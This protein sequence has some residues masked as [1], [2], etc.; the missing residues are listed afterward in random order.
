[1]IDLVI[2][3]LYSSVFTLGVVVLAGCGLVS[4]WVGWLRK[5]GV[6]RVGFFRYVL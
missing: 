5:V 1:M 3:F 2:V 4:F 6:N